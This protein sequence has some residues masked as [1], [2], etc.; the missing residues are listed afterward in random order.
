MQVDFGEFKASLL[1]IVSS[2][3]AIVRLCLKTKINK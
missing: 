3:P 1:G 2:G